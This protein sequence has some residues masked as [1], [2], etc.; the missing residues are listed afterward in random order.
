MRRI[1]PETLLVLF[2]ALSLA[3]ASAPVSA[4]DGEGGGRRLER[5][6][7]A[8]FLGKW[9]GTLEQ[10]QH[11]AMVSRA[12]RMEVRE[13]EE[14][15]YRAAIFIGMH[16]PNVGML[17]TLPPRERDCRV[18]FRRINN[19]PTMKMRMGH[20]HYELVLRGDKLYG[21]CTSATQRR[22]KLSRVKSTPL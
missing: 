18:K 16:K 14:G 20:W 12:F 7:I 10:E 4:G 21:E 11:R 3:I 8:P 1:R 22:C 5:S 13:D 9:E 17:R 2:V 19:V 15:E 6:E